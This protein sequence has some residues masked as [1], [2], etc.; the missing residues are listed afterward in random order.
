[1]LVFPCFRRALGLTFIYDLPTDQSRGKT[2]CVLE[3]IHDV[4]PNYV[5]RNAGIST[6]PEQRRRFNT[7]ELAR[8]YAFCAVCDRAVFDKRQGRLLALEHAL[9]LSGLTRAE[10]GEVYRQLFEVQGPNGLPRMHRESLPPRR[11]RR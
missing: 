2:T 5:A 6:T 11:S 10:R 1:M 7:S 9:S 4:N 8:G 3:E